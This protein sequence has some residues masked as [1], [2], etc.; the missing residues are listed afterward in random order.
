MRERSVVDLDIGCTFE[1]HAPEPTHCVLLFEPH[2]SEEPRTAASD[3]SIRQHGRELTSSVYT[4]AFGNRCRRTTLAA[5]PAEV[6]YAARVEVDDG[7]DAIDP[8]AEIVQP[9]E[10][11][12]EVLQFLLP[13]RYCES[14]RLMDLAWSTFAGVT[15]GWPLAAAVCDWVHDRLTFQYG[16]SSPFLS[17][18]GALEQGTGVCRDFTHLSIALCRALNLPARYV[19][20]Y[21]P[22]IGV[23]DLG[24]PMDFC[25]WTEVHLGGRWYT[26][27]PRNNERRIGRVVVARGRDAADVAMLTSFGPLQLVAMSV[28][29]EPGCGTSWIDTAPT[30]SLDLIG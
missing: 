7:P 10:L 4:D 24:M 28:R 25:A 19:C 1:L 16:S 2:R 6:R 23:P 3:L 14:D 18:M 27:D 13:S 21:L 9:A 12:D 26:F 30:T 20:G 11:S 8:G 17:A 29:A 22:D 15:P 5:G